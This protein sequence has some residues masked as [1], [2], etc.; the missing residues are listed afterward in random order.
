[1]AEKFATVCWSEASSRRATAHAID[2][3]HRMPENPNPPP[4]AAAPPATA[5]LNVDAVFAAFSDPVRHCI[6][7][8]LH[9]GSV[10]SVLELAAR[11]KRSADSIAKQC[12]VLRT[13][14]LIVPADAPDGDGR[15]QCYQIPAVFRTRD[16][17]GRAALDFGAVLIRLD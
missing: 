11:F 9:D 15:K 5:Q 10:L 3:I 6:L 16:I 4:P 12:R 2:V 14:G 1:M 13:A 7:R 17:T 8:E